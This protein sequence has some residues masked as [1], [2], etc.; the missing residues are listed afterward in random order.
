MMHY[1]PL[2]DAVIIIL[3]GDNP[4]RLGLYLEALKAI[5]P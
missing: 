3:A 5:W 2:P 1:G 4:K